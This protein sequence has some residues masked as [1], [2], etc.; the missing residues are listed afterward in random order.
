MSLGDIFSLIDG[1]LVYSWVE[2]W[3]WLIVLEIPLGILAFLL[4]TP[5]FVKPNRECMVG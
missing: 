2:S 4:S 3:D 5:S 1:P